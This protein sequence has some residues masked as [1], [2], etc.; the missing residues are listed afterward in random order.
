[1]KKREV[2]GVHPEQ[3][4]GEFLLLH[5]PRDEVAGNETVLVALQV[6]R[7]GPDEGAVLYLPH[8]GSQLVRRA[9]QAVFTTCGCQ[10]ARESSNVRVTM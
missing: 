6:V 1:M 10:H 8:Q 5:K 3:L 4:T 2:K 7:V 9:V